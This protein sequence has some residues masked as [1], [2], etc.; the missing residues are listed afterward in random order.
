MRKAAR[1]M[2]IEE[3]ERQIQ[4]SGG[5]DAL[6][7]QR[8]ECMSTGSHRWIELQTNVSPPATYCEICKVVN[9]DGWIFWPV[10]PQKGGA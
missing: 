8:T 9:L 6:R 3:L 1:E 2:T 7:L 10:S 5:V 4:E